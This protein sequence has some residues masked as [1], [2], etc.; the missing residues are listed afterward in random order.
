MYFLSSWLCFFKLYWAAVTL[1][2][3]FQNIA[4]WYGYCSH[5]HLFTCEKRKWAKIRGSTGSRFDLK[6]W[7]VFHLPLYTFVMFY[8]LWQ[9]VKCEKKYSCVLLMGCSMSKGERGDFA[10]KLFS[11]Y[12]WKQTEINEKTKIKQK[13]IKNFQQYFIYMYNTW[14]DYIDHFFKV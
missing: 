10:A 8:G 7:C 9:A 13:N 2:L 4:F 1:W 12:K 6:S 3:A 11:R 14:P 5:M